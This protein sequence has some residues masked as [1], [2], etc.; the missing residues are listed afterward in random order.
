MMLMRESLSANVEPWWSNA[1]PLLGTELVESP[2]LSKA[3]LCRDSQCR[4]VRDLGAEHYRLT[5]K[6]LIEPLEHRCARFGR[7]APAPKLG[8]EK[9]AQFRFV[10][11]PANWEDG[12]APVDCD[13]T[14]HF[15]IDFDDEEARALAGDLGNFAFK[16][17]TGRRAPDVS[18]DL[19]RAEQVDCGR[20]IPGF[21]LAHYQP[22][23]T[24]GT[25]RPRNS[26]KMRHTPT[27]AASF[28]SPAYIRV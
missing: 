25:R 21:R 14:N 20:A 27:L 13:E 7:I 8:Q 9:I 24:P 22:L 16:L 6:R 15:P 17:L 10:E 4:A 5:R 18:A 26:F 11:S 19:G 2:G 12:I 1:E 3:E 28:R 23:R